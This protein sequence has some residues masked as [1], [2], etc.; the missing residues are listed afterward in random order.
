MTRI[1]NREYILLVRYFPASD[2]KYIWYMYIHTCIIVCI[3]YIIV[4]VMIFSSFCN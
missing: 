4:H 2:K 3:N 1:F